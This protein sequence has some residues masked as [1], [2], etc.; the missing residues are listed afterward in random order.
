MRGRIAVLAAL[1]AGALCAQDP[2][3]TPRAVPGFEV[4]DPPP[5]VARLIARARGTGFEADVA[6]R[7]LADTPEA[8]PRVRHALLRAPHPRLRAAHESQLD[9]RDARNVRRAKAWADAGRADLLVEAAVMARTD[10]DGDA[11]VGELVALAH[12]ALERS[13][14]LR[15][16]TKDQRV[17]FH[18][19]PT[20]AEFKKKGVTRFSGEAVQ[21]REYEMN[22]LVRA[23]R[24]ERAH[25]VSYSLAVVRDGLPPPAPN[26]LRKHWGLALFSNNDVELGELC[27]CFVLSD[28]DVT[29]WGSDVFQEFEY[30]LVIARGT[31]RDEVMLQGRSSCVSVGGDLRAK[32]VDRATDCAVFAGGEARIGGKKENLPAIVN[33]NVKENPFGVRFFETDELGVKV[34]DADGGARLVRVDATSPL[35]VHGLK[36]GDVVFRIDETRV[37]NAKEFR[38]ELRRAA[39]GGNGVFWVRGDGARQTRVVHFGNVFGR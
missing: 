12:R 22:A 38:R 31:V 7:T 16:I 10:A 17:P 25:S 13:W 33:S 24:V 18:L 8:E 30:S 20:L 19:P 35:A 1:C 32:F 28:G 27:K 34:E 2:A 5:H 36:V 26:Y 6:A 4:D 14:E 9:A 23:A 29:K 15:G 3:P 11:L 39:V 21:P 37:P